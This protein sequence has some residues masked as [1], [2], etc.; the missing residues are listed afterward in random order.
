MITFRCS[1]CKNEIET[2]DDYAGRTARCPTC[3]KTIRVPRKEQLA[4]SPESGSGE[5][6]SMFRVDGRVYEVRPKLEGMLLVSSTV[7]VLAATSFVGVGLV[8]QVYTPWFL[9]ALIGS[10]FAFLGALLCLPGYQAIRA[11]NGLKT[12]QRLAFLNVAAAAVLIV[13]FLFVGVW[14]Y[15][16]ADSSSCRQRLQDVYQALREYAVK[17]DGRLPPSPETLV[18]EGLLRPSKLTCREFGGVREG[19]PTY[20][21]DGIRNSYSVG[22]DGQA[23]ADFRDDGKEFP[24]DLMILMDGGVHRM[25]DEKTGETRRVRYVLTL[26][27]TVSYIPDHREALDNAFEYRARILARVWHDRRAVKARAAAPEGD[28]ATTPK[29]SDPADGPDK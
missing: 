26:D 28:A 8:A 7:V 2:P 20:Y 27:G 15:M 29:E 21:R 4:G 12:G 14:E 6:S 11:S 23:T 22:S 10:G 16:V 19:Y 9:A 17:N 13:I 5:G 24:G 3:G 25:H 18:E 1:G